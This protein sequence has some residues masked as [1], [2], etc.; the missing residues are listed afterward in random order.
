MTTSTQTR[1]YKTGEKA[2]VSG[3]YDF[4]NYV[5]GTTSP[6]P[7]ANERN[8]YLTVGETFPPINSCDKAAYWRLR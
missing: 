3:S 6:P 4:V 8:I 1:L 5:D 2:P 7:T